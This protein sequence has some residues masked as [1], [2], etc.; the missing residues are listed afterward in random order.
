MTVDHWTET[1]SSAI[2]FGERNRR[3]VVLKIVKVPCDEWNAGAVVAAFEG[4]GVVRVLEHIPGAMLLERVL[5]GTNLADIVHAGRDED[6]TGILGDVIATMSPH[7]PLTNCPT[8]ELWGRAFG[9]YRAT[10]DTQA[11]V[12]LVSAAE[13]MYFE[14]CAT[15]RE[16]RLLHGDLQHYNIIL[17]ERRGWLAIDPKGIIAEPEFELGSLLR[18]PHGMPELYSTP[19]IVVRRLTQLCSR[20]ALD[21]DRALRWAFALSV[22]SVI[23]S[24]EDHGSVTDADPALH[25]ARTIQPMLR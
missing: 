25:L 16:T 2:A 20:L 9:N 7:E 1:A 15:Q 13:A 5:P 4:H 11:L 14:L 12:G 19:G 23:W 17:D 10:S 18:N 3:P 8:A 22:L 21:Y 24:V 6:A